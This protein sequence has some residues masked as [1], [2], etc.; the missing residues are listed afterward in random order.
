MLHN[1]A[2]NPLDIPGLPFWGYV[3]REFAIW[4]VRL[5]Y[6]GRGIRTGIALQVVYPG[7]YLRYEFF[8]PDTLAPP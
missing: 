3:L 5:G 8:M 1:Q 7:V 4:R 6:P 2:G